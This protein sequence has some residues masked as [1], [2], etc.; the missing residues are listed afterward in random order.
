MKGWKLHIF[1][2][3]W[4]PGGSKCQFS[5]LDH[6]FSTHN[7][8]ITSLTFFGHATL[9]F[10]GVLKYMKKGFVCGKLSCHGGKSHQ[11]REGDAWLKEPSIDQV[12]DSKDPNAWNISW[13]IL[14]NHRKSRL[15]CFQK[16]VRRG[17]LFCCWRVRVHL[18]SLS[19][20]NF[21][22]LRLC[23]GCCPF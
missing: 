12:L 19:T 16:F 4:W 10:A 23:F 22:T 1:P 9:I 2:K 17:L 6:Q 8:E 13:L 7:N 18:P 15:W 14:E 20:F 11:F 3:P 21:G 5:E